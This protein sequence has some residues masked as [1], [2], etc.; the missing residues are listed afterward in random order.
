MSYCLNPGCPE[1]EN[2]DDV[3]SCQ[4]CGLPLSLKE[5]YRAIKPIGQGGFGKTFLAVDEDMP[6]KRQ[7]VIKQF[8]NQSGLNAQKAKEL[9][10]QEAVQLE[11]L[12][13]QHLQIPELFA[14][15]EVGIGLFLVQEFIDGQDLLQ[16]LKQ[17]GAFDEAKIRQLLNDL[18][19]VLRFI[20]SQQ[21]IHR[22]IKPENIIRRQSDGK[23]VLVDFGVS[24]FATETALARTGTVIGSPG[25][26]AP[27]Q[28]EG[29]VYFSSDLF[30]LGATCFHLLTDTHPSK[31]FSQYGD[32]KKYLRINLNNNGI[33]DTLKRVLTKLLQPEISQRYQSAEEVIQD[34]RREPTKAT[35][36][37]PLIFPTSEVKPRTQAWRCVD[38]LTG[39][40]NVIQSVAISAD[41]A[42]LASGSSDKTIKVWDL[43]TGELRHTLRGHS[44]CI[45]SLAISPD[46]QTLASCGDNTTKIWDLKTGKLL[47]NLN[48]LKSVASVAISSEGQIFAIGGNKTIKIWNPHT[49]EWPRTFSEELG[50]VRSVAISPDGHTLAGSN[51]NIIKIWN[52]H[53][54]Q[55]LHQLTGHSDTVCSLA[56]SPDSQTLVS[57]SF[58]KTVKI[59]DLSTAGFIRTLFEQSRKVNSVAISPDGYTLAISGYGV[60]N[61][62]NILS[63]EKLFTLSDISGWVNSIAISL[64]GRT[65]AAGGSD[66]TI[67]IWRCD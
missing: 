60:I 33:G 63:G 49:G 26:A 38:T 8:F 23:P 58:D 61:I 19:L 17:E 13:K 3:H 32:W 20:H 40:S 47:R 2:P 31:V 57:G 59:W 28:S 51:E 24:K 29:K 65:L 4:S 21:V 55:L 44:L 18:L 50:Y 39:H 62:L 66:R 30:G 7:C 53:T 9:F 64:D 15:V 42:I 34:L 1:P 6:S 22:D 37:S 48:H 5:R 35:A 12:G 45:F 10:V 25:Y 46:G 16:E 54:G 41:S 27:E 52:L 67:K 11:K 43:G 36:E 56:I 14:H